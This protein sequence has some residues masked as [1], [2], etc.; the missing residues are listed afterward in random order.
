[1][2]NHNASE[3]ERVGVM[4]LKTRLAAT[5]AIR[6]YR[7]R[8]RMAADRALEWRRELER[9]QEKESPHEL[10]AQAAGNMTH[11][12]WQARIW[13]EAISTLRLHLKIARP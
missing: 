5:R 7:Q 9:R 10:V 1:M 2:A 12:E 6:H 8:R 4:W 3:A 11:W 13:D